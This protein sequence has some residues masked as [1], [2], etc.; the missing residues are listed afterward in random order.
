MLSWSAVA[1]VEFSNFEFIWIITILKSAWTQH[2]VLKRFLS[3]EF[4]AMRILSFEF[5]AMR[6]LS[7]ELVAYG[8]WELMN[9][10]FIIE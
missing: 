2:L 9:F 6:I 5:V 8:D 1:D 10:E 4:V 7:F 3:F